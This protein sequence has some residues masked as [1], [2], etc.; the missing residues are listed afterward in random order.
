[1]KPGI[2]NACEGVAFVRVAKGGLGITM[3]RGSGGYDP[4]V[5][6]RLP[7]EPHV[8]DSILC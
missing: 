3:A 6:P 5:W 2:F 8:E 7:S 4:A 1:M